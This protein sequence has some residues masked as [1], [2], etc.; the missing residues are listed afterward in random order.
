[1]QALE[2]D[3]TLAEAHTSLALV[4]EH[5]SGLDRSRNRIPA[6]H[7]VNPN[8]ATAHHWYGDYLANM[9]RPEE[10]LR[11]T[12]R[13]Q[14]LDPL[15]LIINT[16]LGWQFYLARRSDQAIDQLRRVLDIDA[17]FTPARA[18][19]RKSTHS[20]ANTKKRSKREKKFYHSR[21]VRSSPLPSRRIFPSTDTKACSRG[22][23]DGLAESP[24]MAM[25]LPSAL[26]R[27]I[28]AWANGR[29]RSSGLRRLTK[30][31]TAGSFRWCRAHVRLHSIGAA[32]QG[33]RP[34]HEAGDLTGRNK[35]HPG[36]PYRNGYSLSPGKYPSTRSTFNPGRTLRAS[37]NAIAPGMAETSSYCMSLE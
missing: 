22:W 13:A 28:C 11:E 4:K 24:N 31:T 15:S 10:G 14:E 5:L 3:D 25:S 21:G 6:G 16:T 30:S 7:R 17:K 9:G 29:K 37:M 2:I 8:S 26:Q 33:N 23:L 18:C 36:W 35:G 34:A 32:F 12:K 27:A 19:S 20:R 1:M